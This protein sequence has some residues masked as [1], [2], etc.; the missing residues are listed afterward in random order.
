MTTALRRTDSLQLPVDRV[1]NLNAA[2]HSSEGV[3]VKSMFETTVQVMETIPGC[4]RGVV[5]GALRL[6][7]EEVLAGWTVG[8]NW[9]S[10]AATVFDCL[11]IHAAMISASEVM[12][13]RG[14]RGVVKEGWIGRGYTSGGDE[15]LVLM[16]RGWQSIFSRLAGGITCEIHVAAT[17]FR[18]AFQLA[19]EEVLAGWTVGNVNRQE[20]GW[21][22]SF[23]VSRKLLYR[24]HMGWHTATEK[25]A[26]QFGPLQPR[27]LGGIGQW[28]PRSGT[29]RQEV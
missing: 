14:T 13:R 28:W 2:F 15:R 9:F 7:I 23:S 11:G 4:M 22:L 24:P 16:A 17:G 6:T 20:R 5:G 29:C 21:K 3:D 10:S 26:R 18:G 27:F 25:F 12:V 1:H 19:I 8:S